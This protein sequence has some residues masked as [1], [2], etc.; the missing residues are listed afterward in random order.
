M[1]SSIKLW[2][3]RM[4]FNVA[5]FM[6][7]SVLLAACSSLPPVSALVAQKSKGVSCTTTGET[8]PP[9]SELAIIALR[10]TVETGP[11]YTIPAAEG[12]VSCS[13]RHEPDTIAIE[14][15]FKNGGWL[16]VKRNSSIEYTEQE[17]RFLLSPVEQ[18]TAVLANAERTAFGT[19]GCGIDWHQGNRQPAADDSSAIEEVF[20]GDV[21][22]CQ[23]RVRRDA[24]GRVV[25]LLL[26][27]AC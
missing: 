27:S 26:R 4:R 24:V 1:S 12:V 3:F 18:P 13:V 11:L 9:Q 10:H 21:C 5:V 15:Q 23:G 14:Y 16:R 17:A 19:N 7:G 25:G 20:R 2:F 22:N 8:A 6:C